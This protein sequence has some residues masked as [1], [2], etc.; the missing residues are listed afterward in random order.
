MPGVRS[1][2][3]FEELCFEELCFEAG[4]LVVSASQIKRAPREERE[5]ISDQVG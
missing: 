4:S 5:P 3:V 1:V 2:V